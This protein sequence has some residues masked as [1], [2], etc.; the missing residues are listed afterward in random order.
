MIIGPRG[1]HTDPVYDLSGQTRSAPVTADGGRVRF[2]ALF[3]PTAFV[4][5]GRRLTA[6]LDGRVGAW[7]KVE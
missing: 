1:A 3:E 4:F 6:T 5:V 7:N 2:K